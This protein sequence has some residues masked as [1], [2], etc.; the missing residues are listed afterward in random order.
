MQGNASWRRGTCSPNSVT[1]DGLRCEQ[2]EQ[3]LYGTDYAVAA[4]VNPLRLT[5]TFASFHLGDAGARTCKQGTTRGCKRSRNR[6]QLLI[7]GIEAGQT[8]VRSPKRNYG[9]DRNRRLDTGGAAQTV[10]PYGRLKLSPRSRPSCPPKVSSEGCC[11]ME[12][13]ATS[14]K[15]ALAP[16]LWRTGA[17]E[18]FLPSG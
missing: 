12:A 17:R 2:H 1:S 14:A 9:P 11:S 4:V 10:T 16:S 8:M 5:T 6:V 7:S 15:I 13:L 18:V 3:S